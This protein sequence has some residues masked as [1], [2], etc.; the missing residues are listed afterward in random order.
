[1][2]AGGIQL[3]SPNLSTSTVVQVIHEGDH[4]SGVEVGNEHRVLL[5]LMCKRHESCLMLY[6]DTE[7]LV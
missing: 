3:V 1:M 4:H 5:V 7:I 2:G 6:T